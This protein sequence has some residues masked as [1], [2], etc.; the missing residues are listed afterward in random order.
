M[1]L[2]HVITTDR[3][4]LQALDRIHR[5]KLTAKSG[6]HQPR[7]VFVTYMAFHLSSHKPFYY[8]ISVDHTGP[9]I[10][11]GCS[12]EICTHNKW[13]VRKN[14]L[15]QK[16]G[17]CYALLSVHFCPVIGAQPSYWH[18][19]EFNLWHFSNFW[20]DAAS[21]KTRSSAVAK[22]PHDASCLY[23]I[24][25]LE[26]CGYPMMKKIR[27]C[28]CVLTWSTNVKKS[29]FSRTAAH[30][31]VSPGDAP[32]TITQYVA[33]MERQFNTCQNPRSMWTIFNS[34]RVK[35]CLS[36]HVS[37][38]IAIFTTFLFPLGS[39]WPWG[40]HAKCCMD[41]K[42]IR[43]LRIVSQHVPIYI[44]QFPS[45]SNRK[46]KKSPFSRPCWQHLACYSVNR[47]HWNQI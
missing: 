14:K 3:H 18:M 24:C 5:L 30:I 46:C 47:R 40:N 34:F 37:P 20:Y 13:C 4:W 23:S 16:S 32:A 12:P 42:R 8:K 7:M 22:R 35:R 10:L 39:P 31:F 15:C 33:W 1:A 36:Q 28:L 17:K 6:S 21:Y 41:G 25:T 26:W 29:P 9:R 11:W 19:T 45:Y 2:R 27:T 38:K 43:C 44:Q